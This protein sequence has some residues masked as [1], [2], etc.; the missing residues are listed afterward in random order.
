[1]HWSAVIQNM[2]IVALEIH[3][4]LACRILDVRVP[5]IPLVRHYPIKHPLPAR[6]F[7]KLHRNGLLKRV[8]TLTDTVTRNTPADRIKSFY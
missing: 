3:D 1:M 7:L 8:Q 2:K 6:N 5:D 4:A